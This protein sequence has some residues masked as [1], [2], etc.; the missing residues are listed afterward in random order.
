MTGKQLDTY[1]QDIIRERGERAVYSIQVFLTHTKSSY[2][3]AS[4]RAL[5]NFEWNRVGGFIS[6]PRG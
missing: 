5:I 1:F 2:R 6:F 4:L 3:Q